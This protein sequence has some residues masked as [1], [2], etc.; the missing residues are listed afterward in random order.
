MIN[1]ED[2][3]G[4]TYDCKFTGDEKVCLRL[5]GIPFR[6]EDEVIYD[7]FSGYDYIDG[8][9]IIGVWPSGKRTG[10]A[11]LLFLNEE[12]AQ[13]AHEAKNGNNIQER[14]IELY[15]HDY[16]YY[17]GFITKCMSKSGGKDKTINDILQENAGRKATGITL[18]GIPFDSQTA[19]IHKFMDGYGVKNEDI[20]FESRNGRPSGRA[21]VFLEDEDQAML[22]AE[23]LHKKYIGNRYIEVEPACKAGTS[24]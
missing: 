13:K 21:I 6:I 4:S 22:A 5:R 23:T 24:Y 17:Q 9:L 16:K 14:W 7:F 12:D 11:V 8:S 1:S 3:N 20:Y 18:R 15:I 19:D 2:D 10:E